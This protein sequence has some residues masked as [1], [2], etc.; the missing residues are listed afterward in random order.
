MI[1]DKYLAR[2]TACYN[3]HYTNCNNAFT[4]TFVKSIPSRTCD[5][6]CVI[7]LLCLS[8]ASTVMGKVAGFKTQKGGEK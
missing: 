3:A 4:L 2:G 1:G 5:S 6:R 7:M 8:I